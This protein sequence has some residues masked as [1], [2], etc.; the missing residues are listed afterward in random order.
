MIPHRSTALITIIVFVAL[1]LVIFSSSPT[2]DPST[3]EEV[4]GPAKYVPH[5]KLPSLNNLHLPSFHPTVHTPPEPQPNST[6]GESKWFSDWSWINPFSSSITLDENRS[7]LPPLRNRPFIYTYY[8]PNKGNDREE[9]NADA[10][11]LLA[12]RRAW[13]AQG[14]RP[15]ILGPGEAMNNQLYELVQPLNLKPELE[16]ELFR[17]L[18][19]GHMGDGMLAD[20][21]CFPMARYDNALLTYLR[22]GTDPALI[23]RFDGFGNALFAGE[24]SRINDAIKE[25]MNKVD[26]KSTSLIDLLPAEF[27]KVEE[28]NALALYDSTAITSHY[29]TVAEKIVSSPTAGR[30]ALAEL[31][32]AHLHNTFQNSF[33]AGIAVLKPFPE[34]TTALVEPALRLAKALVQ[35]PGSPVPR[36]CPPNLPKCHPCD[37]EKPMQVSQPATYRNTTQVFT[38]GTLPHPFTLISL[39]QDSTEVT[40]RHI[41]RETDRDVWLAEVTKEHLGTD[42]GGSARAVVFKRAVADDAVV[43]TSLW[44]TVESLP[45]QAGQSLPSE[46]LDEFEWQFGFKIPRD[47][48]VDAKN[49]EEKKESI[50]QANPSEQGV[51]KEYGILKQAREFLKGKGTNRIGIT[52]VAEAWNLADTEVWRFVRAYRARSVV[53]RKKWEEEEKDFIGAK[54]KV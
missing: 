10:Q 45:P 31:I 25:A 26:D 1:V 43:G 50:Q 17:W 9:D 6:S 19:W 52:D 39:Q 2:T 47:G 8:E 15:V 30:L 37:A 21:H 12:W 36:S 41:R 14:F 4:S 51:E 32:N 11:L 38:I 29:P 13:F 22:R 24:K 53:E 5:P 49:E 35:C 46:L 18:A 20:W 42:I 27:F 16:S 48:K 33:P 34:H 28:P 23:T 40:T 44:M 3:G 7:V 54:P